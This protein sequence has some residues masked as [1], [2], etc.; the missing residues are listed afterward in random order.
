MLNPGSR[1]LLDDLADLTGNIDIR[2]VV[3]GHA[4][5]VPIGGGS[6]ASNWELSAARAAGVARVLVVSGQ[7]PELVRVESYGEFKPIANN[8]TR[9]GRAQ[10]RRVEFSYARQD[11]I[12]ALEAWLADDTAA[13]EDPATLAAVP[14]G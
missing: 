9:E 10:N 7:V 14:A 4:D 11:I 8:D 6:F 13:P 2:L 1:A 12:A 3:S 5:N